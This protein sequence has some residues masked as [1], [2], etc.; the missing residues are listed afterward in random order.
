MSS[1]PPALLQI[2]LAERD[3]V[4]GL[5]RR[6]VRCRDAAEDLAHE[7]LL[8][9]WHRPMA[10]QD[11]SLVF[12]TAQNLA[13]DHLRSRQVRAA[14]S[15]GAIEGASDDAMLVPEA[16]EPQS[17]AV[18][19]QQFDTLVETLRGLPERTQRIFLLNRIDELSY[20][21]IARQLGV[22]VSTVEKEMM[23]ALDACRGSFHD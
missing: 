20:A 5:I 1:S 23:R 3:R 16:L 15:R 10:D 18:A 8:R 11:R 7:T 14:Y 17:S 6:I 21:E 19:A 22:S 2:F 12:R 9:L 13:I 4:V